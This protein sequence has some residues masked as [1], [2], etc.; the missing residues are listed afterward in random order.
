MDK[1]TQE[2]RRNPEKD[3]RYFLLFISCLY[4][5]CNELDFSTGCFF[6]SWFLTAVQYVISEA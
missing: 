2:S 1:M 3:Q 5:Y 4:F 6:R